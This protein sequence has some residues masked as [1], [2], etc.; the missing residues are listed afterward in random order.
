MSTDVD[1]DGLVS[2]PVGPDW[3]DSGDGGL[4]AYLVHRGVAAPDR[5][6]VDVFPCLASSAMPMPEALLRQLWAPPRVE[7][8]AVL[9]GEG[10]LHPWSRPLRS[11][12][13]LGS[14]PRSLRHRVTG[15]GFQVCREDLTLTGREVAHIL[16]YMHGVDGDLFPGDILTFCGRPVDPPPL[17]GW[18]ELERRRRLRHRSR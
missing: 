6:N 10:P 3:V 7:R 8:P 5:A 11:V 1:Q 18:L 17:A 14:T 13:W 4:F 2:W 12:L 9:N 15:V 16:D